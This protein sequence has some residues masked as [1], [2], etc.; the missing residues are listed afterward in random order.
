MACQGSY[1]V[2]TGISNGYASLELLPIVVPL[3]VSASG[4]LAY[5]IS[6]IVGIMT[7]QS[8]GM[9]QGS[10]IVLPVEPRLMDV[11]WSHTFSLRAQQS[12]VLKDSDNKLWWSLSCFSGPSVHHRISHVLI[13]ICTP[14][15]WIPLHLSSHNSVGVS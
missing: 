15:D 6:W 8:Q 11:L 4:V 14:H 12:A 13:G 5:R 3:L 7:A 10:T 2:S 1:V 9:Y